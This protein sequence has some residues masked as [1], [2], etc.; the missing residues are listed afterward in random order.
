M[1][2]S[3]IEEAY[4]Q[5]WGKAGGLGRARRAFSLSRSMWRMLECQVRSKHG[6][7]SDV[8]VAWLTAKRMYFSNGATQQLLDTVRDNAVAGEADF[9][10][11]TARIVGVLNDLGLKFHLT[12]GV[13]AAYYGDPRSTQGVD[14]VIDLAMNR[15]ETKMLLDRMSSGYLLSN[16]V[17]TDAIMSHGLFQAIDQQSMIK[18]D[19]HVGGKIPGE[20][21]RSKQREIAPGLVAPIVSKE[22]AIVSKLLWIQQG[23][24]RSRHDVKEMLRRD[25]DLDQNFL[26]QLAASLGV[27]DLL[28]ELDAEMKAGWSPS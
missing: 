10:Q 9:E 22:D 18:I 16:D 17:A 14:I 28:D 1:S 13:V 8:E 7:A 26:K 11:T 12:G 23:S 4:F 27:L 15:P 21:A 6:G 2:S 25:E 20:L 3:L 5:A 19:L 24:H